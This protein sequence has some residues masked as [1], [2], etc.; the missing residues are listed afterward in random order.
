MEASEELIDRIKAF[1]GFRLKAYRC[2]AGVLTIGAGH[3]RGVREGQRITTQQAETLLRG[4]LLPCVKYVNGLRSDWT[5]GQF[6]ALVDFCFNLGCDALQGSTLLSKIMYGGSEKEIRH[7]FGRWIYAKGK[8]L[9]GLAKRR[10]WET[11]RY[12]GEV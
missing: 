2:P 10:K 6:D 8:A 5:Q 4:D 12:F 1:E 11:K 9:P 3:T 7:E